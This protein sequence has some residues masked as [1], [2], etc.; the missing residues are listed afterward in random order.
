MHRQYHRA[1]LAGLALLLPLVLVACA[2]STDPGGSTGSGT[3][4]GGGTTELA[5]G[6]SVELRAQVA[7]TAPA[8]PAK[9]GDA[10]TTVGVDL[11]GAT[12]PSAN[13]VVGPTS[14]YTVLA[15]AAAGAAGST[16][17]QLNDYLGGDPATQ[18]SV[19]TAIDEGVASALA[20]GA[21]AE[22]DP[23]TSDARPFTVQTANSLWS[24]P[25]LPIEPSYLDALASGFDTG[26]YEVNYAADPDAA[27]QTINGWVAERTASLIPELIAQGALSEDTVLTLVNAT[28]LS[29]PWR[30]DFYTSDTPRPFTTADGRTV[31]FSPMQASNS[32]AHATGNGWAAV[33]IPYRG[34]D[35]GMTIVLPEAGAFDTVRSEL[36]EVL[37]SV[38]TGQETGQVDLTMPAFEIDTALSLTDHLNQRGVT[39]MWSEDAAD[40]S[41]IVD[42]PPVLFATE[43]VHQAVISVDEKGT[44]AAAATALSMGAT[45]AP[46]EPIE[47]VVDRSFFFAVHDTST[48]APLFLGQVVDPTA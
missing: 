21:P 19:V 5:A 44:E 2:G 30:T 27:R 35:L 37:S 3:P 23:E 6:E 26:M 8:D 11:L 31:D 14:V 4:T 24:A 25:G 28:Y 12:D 7:R 33:T 45:A 46:A 22:G 9:A 47:F 41:G 36:A 34:G 17:V 10:L 39:A 40:F 18:Q 29:A 1:P 43:L 15:M 20:A 38:R 48:G 42:P 13:A 16:A 32:Y